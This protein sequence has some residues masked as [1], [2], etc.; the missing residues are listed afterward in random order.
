[1]MPDRFVVVHM[2]NATRKAARSLGRGRRRVLLSS[3]T[4]G[5]QFGPIHAGK[6][7]PHPK[8]SVPTDKFIHPI[9]RDK[10]IHTYMYIHLTQL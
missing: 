10:Y 4:G 7:R 3:A 1:M 2:G 8:K 9:L 6:T 5:G